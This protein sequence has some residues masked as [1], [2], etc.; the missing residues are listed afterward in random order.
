MRGVT[1]KKFDQN[2]FIITAS[3][4][5][6]PSCPCGGSVDS[7]L[8]QQLVLHLQ[9]SVGGRLQTEVVI[10]NTVLFAFT[11]SGP[12]MRKRDLCSRQEVKLQMR[13][14]RRRRGREL[15]CQE[16]DQVSVQAT[17]C[18]KRNCWHKHI[19]LC[20][21]HPHAANILMLSQILTRTHTQTHT[22]SLPPRDDSHHILR[23]GWDRFC[24]V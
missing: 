10:F 16:K 12:V 20:N 9:N 3:Y 22:P 13:G 5:Q 21:T 8:L 6:F 4:T 7:T 11:R 2:P 15:T 1:S 19:S 23:Y 24:G 17:L 18:R 14:R